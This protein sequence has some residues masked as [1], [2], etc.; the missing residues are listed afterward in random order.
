MRERFRN[1]ARVEKTHGRRGEV[2]TV[3]VHGL[4]PVLREG[5]TVAVVPPP[6]KGTR[7]H[8]VLS[9]EEGGRSGQRAA[10][11]GVSTIA[12]AEELVG[13][14]LLVSEVSLP[15]DLALHDPERLVGRE[16]EDDSG[17]ALG[18][19]SEVMLGPA[20]DVWVV[21]GELGEV[22]L[23]VIDEVVSEVPAEG[24]IRVSLPAGLLD[25][26]RGR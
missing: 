18:S 7:W 21:R 19:I 5:M 17:R 6:P 11:S 2:V 9:C 14:Y 23:P 22:L 25:E 4:P 16:V 12:A 3:P 15:A 24:P 8:E 10:L 1:I 13:R 20:N 26:G